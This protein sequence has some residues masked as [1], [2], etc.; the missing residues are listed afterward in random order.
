MK[1]ISHLAVLK[2]GEGS[3][4]PGDIY[5]LTTTALQ[6]GFIIAVF[7][8]ILY[9]VKMN[10]SGPLLFVNSAF[11]LCFVARFMLDLIKVLKSLNNMADDYDK[12]K[13]VVA[14]K[15]LN[16][17]GGR[18]SKIAVIYFVFQAKQVQIK[19]VAKNAQE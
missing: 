1:I 16:Y 3:V 5:L 2:V 15:I 6:L 9:K 7:S 19:M 13:L 4:S 18:F 12:D 17:L 8:L 11:I 14:S 10:I